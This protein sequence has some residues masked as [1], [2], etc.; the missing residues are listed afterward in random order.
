MYPP[1]K[2]NSNVKMPNVN[3]ILDKLNN[4]NLPI[5]I[6]IKLRAIKCG[7]S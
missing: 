2:K 7:R 3:R 4:K 1:A 5:L 6:G